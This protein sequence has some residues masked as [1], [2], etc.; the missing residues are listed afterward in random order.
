RQIKSELVLAPSRVIT[1]YSYS[2]YLTHPFALMIGL[3]LLR[4]HSLAL[5][6]M[7]CVI[8]LVVFPVAAYH[9]LEHPLN[10]IGAR[11]AARAEKRYEQL[12]WKHFR[13]RTPM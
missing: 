10:R 6:L 9:L 4:G 3:H 1:R 13:G 11:L 2:V 5:R 8:G 12:E 7:A